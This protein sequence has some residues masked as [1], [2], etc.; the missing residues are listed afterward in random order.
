MTIL[1][2]KTFP[3]A[4]AEATMPVLVDFWAT[5]CMPCLALL[6]VVEELDKEFDGKT[7]VARVDVDENPITA[8]KYGILSIP[9]LMLFIGG[10]PVERITGVVPKSEIQKRVKNALLS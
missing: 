4:I 7:I 5:W 3:A 6:P 8:R 2:D 10:K 1:T 9:T